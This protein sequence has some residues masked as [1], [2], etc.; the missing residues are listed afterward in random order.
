MEMPIEADGFTLLEVVASKN[1][2]KKNYKRKI[3]RKTG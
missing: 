3:A 1:S 2:Y